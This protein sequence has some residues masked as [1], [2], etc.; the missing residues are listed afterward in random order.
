MGDWFGEEPVKMVPLLPSHFEGWKIYCDWC[1]EQSFGLI[2]GEYLCVE[3]I[4]K[5]LEDING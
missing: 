1:G 2:D 3:C 5:R 4:E